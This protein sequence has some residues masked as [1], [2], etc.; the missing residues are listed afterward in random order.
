MACGGFILIFGFLAFNGGSQASITQPGDAAV[1]SKAILN[2]IL[3]ACAGAVT[4]L[5]LKRAGSEAQKWSFHAPLNGSI[6]GMV[7]LRLPKTMKCSP[8]PWIA[9][10]P[11]SWRKLLYNNEPKSKSIIFSDIIQIYVSPINFMSNP[12]KYVRCVTNTKCQVFFQSHFKPCKG[13]SLSNFPGGIPMM[14]S[15]L[16][17]NW[18]TIHC[19]VLHL[20]ERYIEKVS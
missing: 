11:F 15:Y 2:S 16:A 7:S 1:V 14:H 9:Q 19:K 10:M 13:A 8:Q 4:S 6:M 20:P 5:L 3:S 12:I 17:T 18:T